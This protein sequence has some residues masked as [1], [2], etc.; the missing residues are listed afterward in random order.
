VSRKKGVRPF[1]EGARHVELFSCALR[2]ETAEK[3]VAVLILIGY[4]SRPRHRRDIVGSA[5]VK[6]FGP[7]LPFVPTFGVTP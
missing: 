6:V 2:F 7:M 3:D 5:V 1:A 4:R